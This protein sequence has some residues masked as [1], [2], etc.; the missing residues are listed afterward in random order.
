MTMHANH[1][2]QFVAPEN[3]LA[4]MDTL[5]ASRAAR[6]LGVSTTLLYTA[7]KDNAVSKVVEVAAAGAL[8]GAVGVTLAP[9]PTASKLSVE[10]ATAEAPPVRV[11]LLEV[12]EAKLPIIQR[13]AKS[14]GAPILVD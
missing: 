2:G 10:M 11:V 14:L 8:N 3:T 13:L 1:R 7:R 6:A 12:A 5:G 9:K 4:L